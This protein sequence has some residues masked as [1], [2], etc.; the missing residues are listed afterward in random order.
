[1]KKSKSNVVESSEECS[2]ECRSSKKYY[3]LCVKCNHSTDKYNNLRVMIKNHGQKK[4]NYRSY[5]KS[6]KKPNA[7]IEIKF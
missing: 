6:N 3:I 7:L 1:M 4:M 2:V 5:G